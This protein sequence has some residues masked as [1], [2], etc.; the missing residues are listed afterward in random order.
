MVAVLIITLSTEV[1]VCDGVL[2]RSHLVGSGSSVGVI[3][4]GSED[5]GPFLPPGNCSQRAKASELSYDV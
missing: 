4:W 2:M 5:C 3:S 1:G